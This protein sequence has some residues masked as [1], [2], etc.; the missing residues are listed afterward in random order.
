MPSFFPVRQHRQIAHVLESQAEVG[1]GLHEDLEGA[2]EFR[3]LVD[4]SRAQ[5]AGELVEQLVDHDAERLRLHAVDALA[6]RSSACI[7]F[8]RQRA[9]I[10][11][12][13]Q[14][15]S[16]GRVAD[17]M[18]QIAAKTGAACRLRMVRTVRAMPIAHQASDIGAAL[19]RPK[20]EGAAIT[21]QT[22]HATVRSWR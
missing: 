14:G 11:I 1:V 8:I 12:P 10:G 3:E 4:V 6:P 15:C 7:I 20:S 18:E 13:A 21:F 17:L 2:A 16:T 5:I 22:A 9:F 19:Q